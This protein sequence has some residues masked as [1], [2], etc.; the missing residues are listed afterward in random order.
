[1][2]K[3]EVILTTHSTPALPSW[4]EGREFDFCLNQQ[5]KNEIF[6][7]ESRNSRYFYDGKYREKWG[8]SGDSSSII[9]HTHY[10]QI[11]ESDGFDLTS[12]YKFFCTSFDQMNEIVESCRFSRVGS[13][14]EET[15]RFE[16]LSRTLCVK[17]TVKSNRTKS[18][19]GKSHMTRAAMVSS[20]TFTV[21]TT[22][23][24]ERHEA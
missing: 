7:V 23:E 6:A 4:R 8:K 14:G 19:R 20:R 16:S 17:E 18:R 11:F 21:N 9:S 12:D 24:M 5:G 1:M 15:I 3:F 13:A 22:N 10:M 2:D